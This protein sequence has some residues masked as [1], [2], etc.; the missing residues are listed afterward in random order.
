MQ[1]ITL[2]VSGMTCG[3]CVK[4]VEKAISAV[5][6]VHKV[7]VDLAS[8]IATVGGNFSKGSAPLLA[9]LHE[10]GYPSVVGSQA[11]NS[12]ESQAGSCKGSGGGCTC[13]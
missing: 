9:A 3:S 8:G 6:G 13:H 1:I 4:H 11:R 2:K 10:E 12:K 7:E 5:S